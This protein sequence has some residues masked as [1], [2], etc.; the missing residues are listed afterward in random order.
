MKTKH[1]INLLAVAFLALLPC[2][3]LTAKGFSSSGRSSSFSRSTPSPSV[4]K[5]STGFSSNSK[6]SATVPS[7]AAPTKNAFD[8][9]QAARSIA[10]PKP[11][12]EYIADFKKNNASKYPTTFSTP[13]ASRPA[14]IPPTTTYNGQSRPI[15]YNQQ[16]G[17]YGFMNGLGQFMIYDAITD[18][19]TGAFQKD[20]TVYVQAQQQAATVNQNAQIV[21][22]TDDGPGV[23]TF[24]LY[25]FGVIVVFTLIAVFASQM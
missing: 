6:T 23:G 21:P 10:P 18:I 3:D 14:Y 11:K 24:L 16:A 1:L 15:E 22:E 20:Q 8:K 5:P 13:P 4:S 19:A 2:T 7:K 9:S 25:A 12:N 17:G